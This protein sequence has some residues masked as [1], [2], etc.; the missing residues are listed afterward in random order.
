MPWSLLG[1]I[2]A[3]AAVALAVALG[4]VWITDSLT[5]SGLQRDLS[6]VTA[7]RD[8]LETAI[9]G[10]AGWRMRLTTAEG[11]V[12]ELR[13]SIITSN[14]RVRALEA[15]AK[16]RD[17]AADAKLAEVR[18]ER[19]RLEARYTVILNMSPQSDIARQ[20]IEI[21]FGEAP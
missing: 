7:R 16:E 8:R 17:R 9:F 5:I 14:A 2:G 1:M 3:P 19:E 20:A 10:P 6:T 12:K 4:W 13:G 21:V 11:S 18:A 15:Q